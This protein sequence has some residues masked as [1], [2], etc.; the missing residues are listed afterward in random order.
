[1][2]LTHNVSQQTT[3]VIVLHQPPPLPLIDEAIY[4]QLLQENS[5]LADCNLQYRNMIQKLLVEREAL[6]DK[7]A[8]QEAVV[9]DMQTDVSLRQAAQEEAK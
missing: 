6:F 7:L 4:H 9:T 1:M 3:S 5:L 8:M 2:L